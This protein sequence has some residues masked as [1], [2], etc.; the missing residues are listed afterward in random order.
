MWVRAQYHLLAVTISHY[1]QVAFF[2][3]QQVF[4]RSGMRIMAVRAYTLLESSMHISLS[5]KIF[6][7]FMTTQTKG[8]HILLYQIL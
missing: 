8:I 3:Y 4:I 7:A 1:Q 6:D 2:F 5:E